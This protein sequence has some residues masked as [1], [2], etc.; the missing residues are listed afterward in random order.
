M[1]LTNS[2]YDK[3][4]REY[5]YRQLKS[6]R[7]LKSRQEE[8][9]KR[10]PGM[11]ELDEKAASLS[12]ACARS[13][14]LSDKGRP[15]TDAEL[16][17]PDTTT[18]RGQLAGIT[19]ERKRL[20]LQHGYPEDYLEPVYECPDCQDTGYI[21]K[22]PCHCMQQAAID[23]FY[24][25]SGLREVLKKENFSHFSFDCYPAD[26]IA[27]PVNKSPREH[28]HYVVS[29]CRSFL[30]RFDEAP[31]S[32]LFYG[33]TG[34]GKTFLSHCIASE[35]LDT[36]HS[37]LYYSS[38]D[39]F[40]RLGDVMFSRTETAVP[41]SG[42]NPLPDPDLLQECDLLII[43]D[44][45]SELASSFVTSQLF[46]LLNDRMSAGKSTLISTNL[47][48]AQLEDRYTQRV[49][50]RLLSSFTLLGFYGDDIRITSKLERRA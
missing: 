44:L 23:L 7:G 16:S 37:V 35:L 21:G 33:G 27:G 12:V 1:K 50:S 39:L 10:I 2:Q 5:G 45:G 22:N 20:L 17:V 32:L 29:V 38:G 31:G 25:Q 30:A 46:R 11:K 40:Q 36:A 48:L 24:T 28:M 43:D 8:V 4:M 26:R 9:L 18:L 19:R 15:D 42:A 47:S 41:G 13:F 14:L 34:L 3:I 6:R 49:S